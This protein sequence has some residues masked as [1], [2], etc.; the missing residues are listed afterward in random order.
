MIILKFNIELSFEIFPF[1]NNDLL[2]NFILFKKKILIYPYFISITF[3]A[4]GKS[5]SDNINT[6]KFF[7]KKNINIVPHISCINLNL[8]N[9]KKNIYYY[10]I[11]NID[12]ILILKGDEIN[13]KN[14][15]YSYN[16]IKLIKYIFLNFFKIYIAI[17]CEFHNNSYNYKF[18]LKNSII[19]LNLKIKYAITQYFYNIDSYFYFFDDIKKIKK[20]N[21]YI[22]PG[23]MP[24]FSI[25]QIIKFSNLCNTDLPVWIEKRINNYY[26]NNNDLKKISYDIIINLFFK[27]IKFKIKYI[28]IY[29]MNNIYYINNI[30][31]KIL[32]SN[33]L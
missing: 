31:D 18:D 14:N 11:N 3:G 8:N 24:I 21:Y 17:Y 26:F 13:K 33:N 4:I 12:K 30:L 28:H 15:Y 10:Y 23:V 7:I 19:K 5:I 29:T 1:K 32:L 27:L 6:I 22:I 16:L 25:K 9:F 2:K 20:S